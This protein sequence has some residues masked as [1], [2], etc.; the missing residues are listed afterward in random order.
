MKSKF[1]FGDGSASDM[2]AG[3]GNQDT[4]KFSGVFSFDHMRILEDKLKKKYIE[5]RD[6]TSLATAKAFF[7]LHAV[8]VDTWSAKNH[9]TDAGIDNILEEYFNGNGYTATHFVGLTDGTPTTA[10]TDTLLTGVWNE[11]TAYT[12]GVR[13]TYNPEPAVSKSIANSV[14][15]AS[16]SI[17]GS[18]TVGGAFLALGSATNE[19]ASVLVSV[20]AFDAPGD[21]VLVNGDT[22]NVTYTFSG[23]DS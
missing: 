20:V 11:V 16:F 8:K 2:I 18:V 13:Q 3:N 10:I 6:T 7:N 4:M 15:K 14:S 19:T 1:K 23:A 17:N 21:R 5:L 12:E 22:L 9:V